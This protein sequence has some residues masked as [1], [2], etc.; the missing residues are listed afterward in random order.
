[1]DPS[2]MLFVVR[3]V[4]VRG[5]TNNIVHIWSSCSSKVAVISMRLGAAEELVKIAPS[6]YRCASS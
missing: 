2:N 6:Y 5:H 3:I 4:S 1:M